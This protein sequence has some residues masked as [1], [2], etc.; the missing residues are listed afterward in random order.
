MKNRIQQPSNG[1][2][3]LYKDEG[4]IRLFAKEVSL[5]NNVADWAECTEA[6]KEAWEEAHKVEEPQEAEI[7]E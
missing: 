7:I 5:P 2:D 1:F 6:D 3:W 4:E